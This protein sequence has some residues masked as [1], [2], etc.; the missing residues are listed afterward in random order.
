MKHRMYSYGQEVTK[1]IDKLVK[2]GNKEFVICTYGAVGKV[3]KGI[4]NNEFHIDEKYILDD[5]NAN[6][7]NIIKF[8]KYIW[9]KGTYVLIGSSSTEECIEIYTKILHKVPEEYS[10]DL[11]P[12]Q[13]KSIIK[14][15]EWKIRKQIQQGKRKFAIYPYGMYGRLVK[16]ILNNI[17]GIQEEYIVD[18]Y[19]ANNK[20]IVRLNDVNWKED[21]Y[22]LVSSDSQK[23]Y[24]SIR[25]DIV[26]IIPQ[27]YIIDL[28]SYDNNELYK[29]LEILDDYRKM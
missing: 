2:S 3:I 29:V 14:E 18:N 17:F 25:E 28:F 6:G 8:E 13:Y 23:Y 19:L 22:I 7:N 4:L 10:I 26:K 15:I 12:Y 16:K 21:T 20:D 11:V 1:E 9:K 5:M 27:K 24:N